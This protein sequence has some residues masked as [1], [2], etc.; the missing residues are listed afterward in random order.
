MNKEKDLYDIIKPNKENKVKVKKEKVKKTAP[1]KLKEEKIKKT[2][3]Q[4]KAKTEVAVKAE[5]RI[6]LLLNSFNKD[7]L[8][9][10]S[11]V[12][13]MI[14]VCA[15]IVIYY[16]TNVINANMATYKGGKVTRAEYELQYK[17][18]ASE[19]QYNGKT[20]DIIRKELID[21][22]V[23]N[24]LLLAEFNK[25]N[26]KL[27]E[28]NTK[29]VKEFEGN[30]E[31]LKTYTAR[32]IEKTELIKLYKE[33]IMANQY[34]EE[35]ATEENISKDI[36]AKEGENAD[37]NKYVTRHILFA[38]TDATTGEPK[39]KEAQKAK[40]EE[41]LAKIKAGNDFATLAIANS[42]D[43]GSKE[44][45]GLIEAVA[46]KD[47][48]ADQYV[49]AMITLKPGEVYATLVESEYGYHIIKLDSVISGGRLKDENVKNKYS[50][51]KA[52]DM[53]KAS[54]VKINKEKVEK[55]EKELLKYVG[56]A[57]ANS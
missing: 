40:A 11:I 1:V 5:S 45:G 37:T 44:E 43:P 42:E 23:V 49:D 13:G 57:N 51:F 32:G 16:F 25:A 38:F 39:D 18:N 52:M 48:F 4:K 29:L 22:I 55:V 24:N 28:A 8:I 14:I 17:L 3:F 50:Y 41:I 15:G 21:N 27:N 47:M 10:S 56:E 12:L 33:I 35:D 2:V 6:K 30:E 34:S 53:L 9:V 46:D 36:I 7:A 26:M 54:E 20:A 19:M 31:M